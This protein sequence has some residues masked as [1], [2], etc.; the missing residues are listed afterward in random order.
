[1]TEKKILAGDEEDGYIETLGSSAE[2]Y[3]KPESF[4]PRDYQIELF[5]ISKKKNTIAIL[6][7]GTGKTF[8]AIM[9]MKHMVAKERSLHRPVV[10]ILTIEEVNIFPG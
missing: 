7:S 4:R 8:V 2:K 10:I 3:S 9:L 1:M 6:E 5:N